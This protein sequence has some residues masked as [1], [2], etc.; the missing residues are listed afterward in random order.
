MM[1]EPICYSWIPI[2]LVRNKPECWN[3][4]LSKLA[5]FRLRL[6]TYKMDGDLAIVNGLHIDL[7][8]VSGTF[9][10]IDDRCI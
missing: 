7:V 4:H 10:E 2:H 5:L 9:T 3:D 8:R 6:I 1:V